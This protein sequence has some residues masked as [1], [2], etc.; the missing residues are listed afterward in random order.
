MRVSIERQ[1]PGQLSPPQGL[2]ESRGVLPANSFISALRESSPEIANRLTRV[3]M[4]HGDLFAEA[5]D[6]IDRVVFPTAGMISIVARLEDG[7]AV[8]AA[9]VGPSGALGM[10]ALFGPAI[11]INTAFCQIP[12][13][14]CAL[15]IGVFQKAADANPRLRELALAQ[16][17]YILAQ[18]QQ[19]AACNARHQLS[20]RMATW[21]LRAAD[22]VDTD[23]LRLTQE[24]L[25][26]ML[27]V[28]RTSLCMA[29]GQFQERNLINVRRGRISLLDRAALESQACECYRHL[30]TQYRRLNPMQAPQVRAAVG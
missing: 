15:P 21:L 19:A 2:S 18:S 25:A 4:R 7:D 24:Y 12:G 6:A 26:T 10:A 28:Q 9:M 30:R 29:A 27:G 1:L 22:E 14:A 16:E 11:H 5:G 3:E 20:A 13:E 8:E 17:Q 23:G